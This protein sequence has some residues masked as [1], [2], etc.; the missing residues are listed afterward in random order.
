MSYASRNSAWLA[1]PADARPGTVSSLLDL[2]ARMPHAAEAAAELV[3]LSGQK[4]AELVRI[5]RLAG[6]YFTAEA[7]IDCTAAQLAAEAGNTDGTSASTYNKIRDTARARH[8]EALSDALVKYR[9]L[10]V[11]LS[12]ALLALSRMV[13]GVSLATIRDVAAAE[14]AAADVLRAELDKLR[15][16][17]S[18]YKVGTTLAGNELARLITEQDMPRVAIL[19]FRLAA[20]AIAQAA[21]ISKARVQTDA[22]RAA[23]VAMAGFAARLKGLATAAAE[24]NAP[25][26]AE[27]GLAMAG[28]VKTPPKDA[29][30]PLASDTSPYARPRADDPKPALASRCVQLGSELGLTTRQV[31]ELLA[32]ATN[33]HGADLRA[34]ASELRAGSNAQEIRAMR[35]R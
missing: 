14:A 28:Q 33:D 5:E 26:V 35:S 1:D 6:E 30:V 23:A 17:G 29:S 24:G 31:G 22:S 12:R 2:A 15:L 7:R 4:H 25:R 3:T 10:G 27:V 34:L 11:S 32:L 9:F 13:P 16:L 18:G 8:D 21:A 19:C 20:D